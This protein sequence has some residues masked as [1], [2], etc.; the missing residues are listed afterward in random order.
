MFLSFAYLA[1]SAVLELLLGRRRSEFAKDV[2]LLVLRHQ[3]VVLARQAVG[4]RCGRPIVPFLLRSPGCSRG[5]GET[6]WSLRRRHFCVGTGSWFDASG[7]SRG[8]ARAAR[9]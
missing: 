7:R 5:G 2:E 9:R 6:R 3:L 4:R 8:E 1:F